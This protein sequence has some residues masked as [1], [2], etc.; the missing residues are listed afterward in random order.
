[1]IAF[2]IWYSLD[3]GYHGD[4]IFA[5]KALTASDDNATVAAHTLAKVFEN[6]IFLSSINIV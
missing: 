2:G 1:M 6:F 5:A 4:V 3:N